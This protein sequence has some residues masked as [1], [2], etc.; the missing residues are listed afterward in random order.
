LAPDSEDSCKGASAR[1][2]LAGPGARVSEGAGVASPCVNQHGSYGG[3]GSGSDQDVSPGS[4]GSKSSSQGRWVTQTQPEAGTQNS[5]VEVQIGA[6]AA[7]AP[8]EA[9][10]C[11]AA[12]LATGSRAVGLTGDSAMALLRDCVAQLPSPKRTMA[13]ERA[14]RAVAHCIDRCRS[15]LRTPP[16]PTPTSPAHSVRR[17]C[18]I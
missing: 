14:V 12:D 1:S 2:S 8:S 15:S 4:P 9:V 17:L 11:G 10:A 16:P 18:H 3:E 13:R 7:H 5:L 6:E